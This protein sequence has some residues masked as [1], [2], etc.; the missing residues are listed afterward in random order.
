MSKVYLNRNVYADSGV[1]FASNERTGGL[2]RLNANADLLSIAL[3]EFRKLLTFD[4]DV[5]IEF[6]TLRGKNWYGCYD[7]YSRTATLR[8]CKNFKTMLLS[9]AHE[10]VH[11][12]QFR[13]GKLYFKNTGT[14][15]VPYWC[16]KKNNSKD[17]ANYYYNEPWEREARDRQVYLATLVYI[18]LVDKLH[19]MNSTMKEVL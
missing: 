7:D 19:S 9:L 4:Q 17:T 12:E 15:Y 18:S 3:E 10:L 16:G 2:S 6:N 5:K 11:A 14:V 1:Y 13:T 8:Y